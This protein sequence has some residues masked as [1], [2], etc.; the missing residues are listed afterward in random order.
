MFPFAGIVS[1]LTDKPKTVPCLPALR[2]HHLATLVTIL[3]RLKGCAHEAD[4][5]IFSSVAHY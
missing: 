5:S 4:L 1:C 2:L 3:L